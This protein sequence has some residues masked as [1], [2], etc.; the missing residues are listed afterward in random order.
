MRS[1]FWMTAQETEQELN[2][3][4]VLPCAANVFPRESTGCENNG[5][6]CDSCDARE[7]AAR[8]AK[9]NAN[10]KAARKANDQARRDCGLVK[11]KD[12]LG[13]SIWE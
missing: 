2:R 3:R 13:R 4:K 11:G 1:T 6:L 5:D 12:S 10:R 8:K 9:R 7:E